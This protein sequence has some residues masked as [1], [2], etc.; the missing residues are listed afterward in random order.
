MISVAYYSNK[1]KNGGNPVWS[2][3]WSKSPFDKGVVV[4]WKTGTVRSPLYDPDK[5]EGRP[6]V[7]FVWPQW[8]VTSEPQENGDIHVVVASGVVVWQSIVGEEEKQVVANA[9][10]CDG[11]DL[12]VVKKSGHVVWVL[13]EPNESGEIKF[14]E[15]DPTP[16]LPVQEGSEPESWIPLASVV[17][18]EE[19]GI[20]VTQ[21]HGDVIFVSEKRAIEVVASETEVVNLSHEDGS[22]S[23]YSISVTPIS[24]GAIDR[25][26][27][28]LNEV[29][30][31][32]PDPPPDPPG[33]PPCG[34]PGNQ[35]G[36]GAGTPDDDPTDVDN[37][38]PGDNPG[39]GYD[40]DHPGDSEGEDGVTPNSSGDC[41]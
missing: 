3:T 9:V 36:A 25:F 10:L 39:E 24:D 31:P 32:N 12:G 7:G 34:H 4:D 27:I 22:T 41:Q 28:G 16:V 14:I 2:K 40:V 38:H 17:I 37:D 8:N 11:I 29:V 33:P 19:L 6:E 26:V 20:V 18:D 30:I 1:S 13:K 15:G 23:V 35:P 5:S 21:E